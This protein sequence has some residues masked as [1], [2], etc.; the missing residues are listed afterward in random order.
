[1][2]EDDFPKYGRAETACSC[3]CMPCTVHA[4]QIDEHD[5]PIRQCRA[6]VFL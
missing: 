5:D 1:M 3:Q 4:K 2:M 6:A